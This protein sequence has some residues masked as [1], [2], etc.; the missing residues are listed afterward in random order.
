MTNTKQDHPTT[1]ARATKTLRE[2]VERSLQDYFR[3]L[4]GSKATDLYDL[5]LM[6]VEG[7]LLKSVMTYTKD[8]QSKA[9][10]LLG[11][12]RGTLRKKLKQHHII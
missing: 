3:D 4:D 5:V 12:N 11:L 2:S 7:P 10:Q 1:N 8:N 9:A 6:E